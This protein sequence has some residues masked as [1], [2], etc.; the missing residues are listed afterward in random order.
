[1]LAAKKSVT[2]GLARSRVAGVGGKRGTQGSLSL[3][4]SV[5]WST[6]AAEV[7][8]S[9]EAGAEIEGGS[10]PDTERLASPRV[11]AGKVRV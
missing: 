2:K 1:M 9:Y 11:V 3:S 5:I 7:A 8:R 4:S 10:E 6:R